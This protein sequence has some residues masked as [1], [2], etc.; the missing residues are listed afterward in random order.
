MATDSDESD[1]PV[2]RETGGIHFVVWLIIFFFA[3]YFGLLAL[4]CLDEMVLKHRLILKP[5]QAFDEE[6]ADR[7]RDF[8]RFIYAPIIKLVELLRP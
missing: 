4:L 3:T 2:R 7:F 5:L 6:F 8:V 1:P